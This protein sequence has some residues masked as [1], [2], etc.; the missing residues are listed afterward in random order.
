MAYHIT[1]D[2]R[3]TIDKMLKAN[4]KVP[5]I[6]RAVQKNRKNIY[7]EIKRGTIEIWG[8]KEYSWQKGQQVADFNKGAHG[9]DLKIGKDHEAA[10]ELEGLI[11]AGYSPYAASQI[12]KDFGVIS[13]SKN[14]V[15]SYID[16]GVLTV[17]NKDLIMGK[18]KK[19][20]Q[21]I[22][23]RNKRLMGRSIETRPEEVK[24]RK[25]PGHWEGDT[26]QPCKDAKECFLVLTE[27]KRRNE[28]M[29]KLP[30]KEAATTLKALRKLI[31]AHRELFKTITF[32]NGSEFTYA[33]ELE[34]EGV[35]VYFC[36]PYSS[37][38]R[39]SNENQNRFIRRRYPKGTSFKH[40]TD[41]DVA[42]MERFINTY[43]RAIFGGKSSN[44][45]LQAEL[46]QKLQL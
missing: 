2:D 9:P 7:A 13:L 42:N 18:R 19:K 12:L 30:N 23:R 25:T 27:R 39:G 38:E 44:A 46:G 33:S 37:F 20:S 24:T 34:A 15:Y 31:R 32:D 36:H 4:F 45:M 43:P 11:L 41:K 10:S 6:A 28:L 16:S 3:K 26:V 21:A 1:E 40:V 17:T 8:V 14:T 5:E 29:A 35:K 22:P